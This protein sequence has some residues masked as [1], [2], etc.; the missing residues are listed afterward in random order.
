MSTFEKFGRV[1]NCPLKKLT[2]VG[3]G[4]EPEAIVEVSNRENIYGI[5]NFFAKER[6]KW[7]VMGKGT[8]LLVN[9]SKLDFYVLRLSEQFN[10][11]RVERIGD[12]FRVEVGAEFPTA[13]LVSEGANLGFFG[14]EK[15]SGI[16]GN[17]GGAISMNSGTKLGSISDFVDEVSITDE[18]GEHKLKPDFGYRRSG[19]NGVITEAVLKFQ[20][21]DPQDTKRKI[22]HC[23]ELRRR[24]Q[25]VFRKNF[26]CIFKNPQG[27]S[28]GRIIDS[29]GLKGKTIGGVKISEIHANFIDNFAQGSFYDVIE[30]IR[31]V[32]QK[33]FY[34]TGINL[35]EEV[36][37]W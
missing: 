28:A 35:E 16:P 29:L 21:E 1:Y 33:V 17:I 26:G 3:I 22:L 10:F 25:P 4:G 12:F 36:V 5:L 30:L 18:T 24:T 31:E 14:V 15:I 8:K 37:I 34:E 32:K 23:L 27:E 2:S 6:L 9:D 11:F 19:I 7:K 13:S 20:R